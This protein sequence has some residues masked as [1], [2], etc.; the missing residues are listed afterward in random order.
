MVESNRRGTITFAKTGAPNSRAT[1]FFINFKNNSNLDRMGF[2]PFGKVVEGMEAVDAIYKVGEGQPR[3]PG[4]RQGLVQSQGNAYLKE[5][6]PDLDYILS[7]ELVEAT[8]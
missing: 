3:G 2:S 7:A 1:Q 5:S 4:P 6:Y 8:E